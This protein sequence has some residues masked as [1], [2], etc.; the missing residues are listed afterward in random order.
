MRFQTL[1]EGRW[2]FAIVIALGVIGGVLGW[3]PLVILSALLVLFCINFFRDP[4]R[5]VPP[6]EEVVVAAAD[7]VVADIVEIEEDEV[8]KTRCRRVG[9]FLSVFD[10]HVNKAPIAGKITYLQH[11]PGLYLDARNP[12][13]SIKNE[14]L[15]WAIEGSKATLVIRQITGAIAR[16]IVP[17]S[18]VGDQVEKGFRFGMIRFGSRTEI[19]LPMNATVEVKVGDRVVGAQSV[20]ARLV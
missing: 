11:H 15:T 7:G 10:V 19:Y 9:I 13:C 2:I 18:K 20:I 12:E 4:D 1:Y 8:L 5:P 6:G 17:W 14:A 16:R 3:L